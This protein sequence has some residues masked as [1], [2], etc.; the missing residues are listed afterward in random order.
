L[1]ITGVVTALIITSHN[2]K[3]YT[4]KVSQID[5]FQEKN[6]NDIINDDSII[7]QYKT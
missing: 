6:K 4:L 2:S 7:D 1:I 3:T 5:E